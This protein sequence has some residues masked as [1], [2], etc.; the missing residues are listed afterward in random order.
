MRLQECLT[1]VQTSLADAVDK[2]RVPQWP[3][4]AAAAWRQ[5]GALLAGRFGKALRLLRAITAFD[6]ILA[7]APLVSL[8][9]DALITRKVRLTSL[10][11]CSCRHPMSRCS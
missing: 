6:G 11:A 4:G 2:L 1:E 7:Q 10:P 3:H 8:A 9:F 5:A